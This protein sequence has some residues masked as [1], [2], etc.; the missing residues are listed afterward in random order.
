M[1]KLIFLV[2]ALVI[3]MVSMGQSIKSQK[4]VVSKV[5]DVQEGEHYYGNFGDVITETDTLG[6]Y[7]IALDNNIDAMK[8]YARIKLTENSG[9]ALVDVKVQGKVFVDDTYTDL[10]S[11]SYA[12]TGSDTTIV[13]DGTSA[14]E[15]RFYKILLDG[16]G[17]GTFNVTAQSEITFY[18]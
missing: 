8:Q 6:V 3:G 12:G 4:N 5:L 17:T 16:D 1:K 11:V 13:L 9:T 2:A 14:H 10:L 7:T 15:Y 18:K